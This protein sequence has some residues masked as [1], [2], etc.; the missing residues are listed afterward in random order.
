MRISST[1][2]KQAPGG[3]AGSRALRAC[4]VALFWLAL[5]Q[6]LYCLV[7]K[8]ILIVSPFDVLQRIAELMGT[9]EFYGAAAASLLRV[10]C[11]FVLAVVCGCLLA[12]L[13]S[14]VPL[15][16][17]FLSPVL[18]IVKATPVASFIILAIVWLG[19][20]RVPPFISFL[21]VLPVVWSNV[22]GGI[23]AVDRNLLEMA[24]VFRLRRRDKLQKI[25]LPAVMPY[26][27]A[28]C[29]AGAGMAWKAGIAAE[30]LGSTR[31]SIGGKIYESKIYLETVDLFAWTAVLIVLSIL[32]ERGFV[33]LVGWLG[34]RMERRVR[35]S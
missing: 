6:G 26:F 32:F 12:V 34:R 14:F 24:Q 25:Y 15:A 33:A 20:N 2:R 27:M 30:V 1:N 9:G 22:S 17:A 13:T 28:A 18:G 19:G 10:A 4:A 11:G 8:E 29:T 35:T 16:H 21:M 7:E 5:W 3:G 31:L 23:Q